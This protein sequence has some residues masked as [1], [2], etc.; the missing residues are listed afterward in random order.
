MFAGAGRRDGGT[1]TPPGRMETMD[2]AVA[3]QALQTQAEDFSAAVCGA[4]S[5][6]DLLPASSRADATASG[7]PKRRSPLAPVRADQ[8]CGHRAGGYTGT[9]Y[10]WTFRLQS[11]DRAGSQP[12]D[13]RARERATVDRSAP[14]R[15]T[16]RLETQPCP[17][18][19]R[20][21]IRVDLAVVRDPRQGHDAAAS[22]RH[23][24]RHVVLDPAGFRPVSRPA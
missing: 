23:H 19:K 16:V 2:D 22:G 11:C 21:D 8:P 6:P 4:L 7:C 3:Y 20:R 13:G 14:L 18:G 15:R 12:D 9:G 5:G 10:G 24:A 17:G 1:M